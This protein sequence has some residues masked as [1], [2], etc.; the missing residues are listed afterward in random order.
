MSGAD[1]GDEFKVT[2]RRRQVEADEPAPQPTEAQPG[3]A[4]SSFGHP[5]TPEPAPERRRRRASAGERSLEDLFLMLASSAVVAL[6]DAPDPATGEVQRDPAAAAEVIDLLVLLREK[7]Q[8]NRSD[9]ETKV[10][11]GLI[12]DLQLRYI[13]ATKPKP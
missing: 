7:T 10:I 9:R 6:G 8:G 11:E 2:D 4:E 3:P 13:A 5:P 12:Y 1:P